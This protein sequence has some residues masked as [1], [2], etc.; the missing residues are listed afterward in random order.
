MRPSVLEAVDEEVVVVVVVVVVEM[1]AGGVVVVVEVVVV[2]MVAATEELMVSAG[3]GAATEFPG[4]PTSPS[5]CTLRGYVVVVV[6]GGKVVADGE[7]G[8]K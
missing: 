8:G 4:L 5:C 3:E 1:A 2:V 6:D 7:F